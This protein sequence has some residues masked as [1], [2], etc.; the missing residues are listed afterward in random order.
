MEENYTTV[1][2]KR[3]SM[4]DRISFG[5]LLA[6]S[7]LV[8]VFFVPTAFISTQFGTSIL[9]AFGVIVSILLYIIGGLSRGSLDLPKPAKYIIGFLTVVPI[10]YA[11]A[12]IANGFSRMSFLGY[13]FDISTAGFI[14]LSFGY[15]FLV[16][17]LFRSKSRIFYSYFVFLLSSII[18]S[19]FLLVRIIFGAEV[20]SFGLFNTLTSTMIGSWNNVGIFFGICALLSLLTFEMIQG[21]K[22]MKILLSLALLL[23]LFFLALVNFSII[24]V[25]LAITAFLFILYRMFS[26]Q[27]A[28][29]SQTSF[30][31]KLSKIPLYSSIVF[32][33]SLVFV[34]WGATT[35]SYLSNK[36]SVTNVE[37]RPNLSV[38]LDIARNTLQSRPLFGSGP[39]TFAVEWL[40]FRPDDIISTIFWNTDFQ[41]GIGLIPTF[42]VTTGAIGI[43]SWLLFLGFYVYLG[44][45]SIFSPVT[46]V[47]VKYL[48]TSSFF[49]SLYLWIMT[50]VY[51][52]STSIFILTFF[53]S[54]LF[55]ASV[56]LAGLIPTSIHVF[57]RSPKTG[58][59]SSLIM[60]I[61]FIASSALGYGLF[62][63]SQ[64]LWY[65]QKSS[66]AFNTSND[67][68]L[69]EEYMGKAIMAVPSDIYYRALSEIELAKLS[70]ILSQDPKKVKP[71]DAQKQFSETLTTAIKAGIGAKD[72]DPKNYLNWITLGRV[73]EAVSVPEFGIDGAYQSAQFAYNE[74][75]RRNPKNPGIFMLFAWLAVTGKDLKQAKQ[76]AL[77][78]I[79]VKKNYIDAYF[80]LSQIEVADKNIKGA[81]ESVT[82]ASVID[83]TDPGIFFQLGL[84]KYNSQDFD[85]AII[86]LEKAITLTPNYANAKY[87]LGLAYE[88][89]G[90]RTKAIEQFE[91]L[92]ITNPD[93]EEVKTILTNLKAGKPIFTG[94]QSA[95]PEKGKTLPVKEK[96]Q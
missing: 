43:L 59:L 96:V 55:L 67:I 21:S 31:K 63:N 93:S 29:P 54:G 51:V 48:I 2:Q 33:V 19:I 36:F 10:A 57:S 83:P 35:G 23:S 86:A 53:F 47:F 71:E 73:Y 77:Q 9:F 37:V 41:S 42:A 15:L 8:P 62:K 46:D 38:T 5:I 95:K 40:T 14:M 13:T 1:G 79:A 26:A 11:L 50:F 34:I 39:N 64:S 49:V 78:A 24:W 4:F 89:I 3:E 60:V 70:L 52:P 30:G 58:F 76:Y 44:F 61:F 84:L 81:I 75:L 72:A 45:K 66:Y 7:F 18:L 88:A 17:L 32:L 68:N 27:S 91:Q 69:S 90:E 82:A 87:F 28:Y 12:G 25:I 20:L 16:S 92:A 74:A 22:F 94:T 65:F 56:Y 80:L 85:G 6:M